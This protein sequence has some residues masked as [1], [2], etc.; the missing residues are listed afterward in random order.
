MSKIVSYVKEAIRNK[1][2][3]RTRVTADGKLVRDEAT[4][5]L[6][7]NISIYVNQAVVD[8][9][10]DNLLPPRELTFV[11]LSRKEEQR[12]INGDLRYNYLKLETDFRELRELTVNDQHYLADDAWVYF[13]TRYERDNTPRF[14]IINVDDDVDQEPRPRLILYP[15]PAEDDEIT[16]KYYPDGSETSLDRISEKYYTAVLR[17]VETYLNL[18]DAV[19]AQHEID[20]IV[21]QQLNPK[22]VNAINR[23]SGRVRGSYFGKR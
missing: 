18:T 5:G 10:R 15:F 12:K 22:G 13:A 2:E 9:Q 6:L 21:G 4:D 23:S 17:K 19:T 7:Q 3:M 8:L 11:A 16:I 14:T 1:I 20:S